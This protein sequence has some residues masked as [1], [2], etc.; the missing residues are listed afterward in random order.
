MLGSLCRKAIAINNANINFKYFHNIFSLFDL[1]LHFMEF[2][3]DKRKVLFS[4]VFWWGQFEWSCAR[5]VTCDDRR[6][7]K[8]SFPWEE[9]SQAHRLKKIGHTAATTGSESLALLCNSSRLRIF[10]VLVCMSEDFANQHFMSCF[11]FRCARISR[12]CAWFFL[13]EIIFDLLFM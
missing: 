5:L 3:E 10:E 9:F 8:K 6:N 11:V 7:P 13:D 2:Y 4:E 1:F 12:V